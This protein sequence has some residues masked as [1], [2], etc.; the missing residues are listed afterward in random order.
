MLRFYKD[1][2]TNKILHR[3]DGPAVEMDNGDKHW[4]LNG[5]LHRIDGP[6][7]VWNDTGAENWFQYGVAHRVGAPAVVHDRCL[8]WYFRGKLHRLDG[9][10]VMQRATWEATFVIQEYWINGIRYPCAVSY[11]KAVARWLS[12]REVT[13]DEVTSL[14]GNFRIVGWE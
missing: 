7:I 12:Y 4:Y 9:P 3:V 1:P 11:N 2:P 10:A 13:R 6:A 14:I 8:I 5:K